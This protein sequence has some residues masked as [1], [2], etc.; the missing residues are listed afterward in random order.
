MHAV[1]GFMEVAGQGSAAVMTWRACRSCLDIRND[2]SVRHEAP[3]LRAEVKGL[4]RRYV[5]AY[6]LN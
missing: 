3:L 1:E 6:R 5:A 2:F 4:R